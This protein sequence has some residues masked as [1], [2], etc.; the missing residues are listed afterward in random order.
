MMIKLFNVCDV[1]NFCM[2]ENEH[3]RESKSSPPAPPPSPTQAPFQEEEWVLPVESPRKGLKRL[4]LGK[5]NSWTTEVAQ[6]RMRQFQ[7]YPQQEYAP[8]PPRSV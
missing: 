4:F 3:V 8:K 7:T 5:G 2:H 6:P 1:V